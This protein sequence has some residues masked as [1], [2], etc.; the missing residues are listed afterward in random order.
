MSCKNHLRVRRGLIPLRPDQWNLR[1]TGRGC[2]TP[3]CPTIGLK[4]A[5]ERLDRHVAAQDYEKALVLLGLLDG[6]FGKTEELAPRGQ[7]VLSALRQRAVETAANDDAIYWLAAQLAK[8]EHGAS[9][10]P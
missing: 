7:Q 3:A 4:I 8:P 1:D 2:P 9:G 5:S 6:V 10:A